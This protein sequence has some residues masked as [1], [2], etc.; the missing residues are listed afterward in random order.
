MAF[1][2]KSDM[3]M[4]LNK[5]FS[6]SIFFHTYKTATCQ[7]I[8]SQLQQTASSP[9]RALS[10]RRDLSPLIQNLCQRS[11]CQ[12]LRSWG[13]ILLTCSRPPPA[14]CTEAKPHSG[15]PCLSGD[16]ISRCAGKPHLGSGR[17]KQYG[18]MLWWV[19]ASCS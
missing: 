14:A 5:S 3:Y 11:Q 7:K 8:S 1:V 9:L 10:R 6:E 2:L 15:D 18:W 12:H 4:S 13:R 16:Q 17:A 19:R